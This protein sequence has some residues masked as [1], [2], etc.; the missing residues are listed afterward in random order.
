[1]GRH[2]RMFLAGIH[3]GVGLD[4]RQKNAG[5]TIQCY[6]RLN[7]A[8]ASTAVLAAPGVLVDLTVLT[9]CIPAKVLNPPLKGHEDGGVQARPSAL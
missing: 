1:M 8:S 4:S 7:H 5:M 2:S 9:G 6:P 3:R